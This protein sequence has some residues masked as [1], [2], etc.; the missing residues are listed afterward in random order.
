V[1]GASNP[2]FIQNRS[3]FLVFV[4]HELVHRPT[5]PGK[6]LPSTLPDVAVGHY[7]VPRYLVE[8]LAKELDSVLDGILRSLASRQ[9]PATTTNRI[10]V[11][12]TVRS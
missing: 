10:T 6:V 1:L 5:L 8:D 12:R 7:L 9:K 11:V 3:R 2:A 4:P